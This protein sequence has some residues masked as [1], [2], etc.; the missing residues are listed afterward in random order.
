MGTI[1]DYLETLDSGNRAEVTRLYRAARGVVPDATQGTG[2]GMPAL[3]FEGRP[4][5]SVMRT[6]KHFGV[7]PFSP[8]AVSEV[9]GMVAELPGVSTTKGAIRVDPEHP[10]P[11]SVVRA[12][13]RA[14]VAELR[15]RSG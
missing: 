11:E 6:A 10:L 2:Y 14:R 1:D 15:F 8:A 12:L 9:A 4:V 3:L 13:V 7:Y 5:L